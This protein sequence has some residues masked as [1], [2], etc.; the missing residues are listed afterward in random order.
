MGNFFDSIEGMYTAKAFYFTFYGAASLLIP[1]LT[2]HY[3]SLGLNGRQIGLLT[4]IVPIVTLISS[5]IWGAIADATQ[6]HK[7]V[8]LCAAGSMW[9]AVL[10]VSRAQSFAQLIP[11]VIWYAF[12]FA[13]IIPL[14]DNSV[15]ALL[16]ENKHHYGRVRVWG[17]YGWGIIA[18]LAGWLLDTAGLPW[19]F[20]ISLIIFAGMV[21]VAWRMEI[22]PVPLS[23]SFQSGFW[24]LMKNRPWVWFLLVALA[25]GMSLSLFM[26]FLFLYLDS[27]GADGA[28]LG[29]SLT[30]ATLS[31]IPI[32]LT[33]NRFLKRWNAQLLIA[34][35]LLAFTIRAFAYV[36]MTAPWQV[37]IISLLHGL[38]FGIMWLAGVQYA[39][40]IAPDGLG[41]TA[42]GMFGGVVMGLGSALGALLG[43]LLYD[44][45]PVAVFAWAGWI[46]LGALV[47]FVWN[48]RQAFSGVLARP[49][50]PQK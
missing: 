17:S 41:A 35:A 34:I 37:L 48:N 13:P 21:I 24:E 23:G 47:L 45:N 1:F 33:A 16:G 3:E 40:D 19:L 26:N 39:D 8:L 6:K 50:Q 38:S 25:G 5:P 22:R 10:A 4:G 44:I 27:M 2:L 28:I 14:V 15:V 11:I 36:A 32:F 42:Q 46:S 29:Y 9:A 20:N 49:V 18:L 7:T 43:G 12:S 30:L 31:E